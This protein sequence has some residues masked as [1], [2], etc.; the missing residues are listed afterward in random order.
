ML[1]LILLLVVVGGFGALAWWWVRPDRLPPIPTR[2]ESEAYAVQQVTS[3]GNGGTVVARC[4]DA[5]DTAV[6]C[7][8]RDHAG[9]SWVLTSTHHLERRLGRLGRTW[10]GTVQQEIG[11]DGATSIVVVASPA[12]VPTQV[13]AEVQALDGRLGA[14]P[15]TSRVTCTVPAIGAGAACSATGLVRQAA[16]TGTGVGSYTLDLVVTLPADR[17]PSAP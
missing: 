11:K 17:F 7:R 6:T 8:L 15:G 1:A 4:D 12:D 14:A 2:A 3:E 13:T 10:S 9:T 16:L 5:T